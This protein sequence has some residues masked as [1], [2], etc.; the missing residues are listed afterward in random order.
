M[1]VCVLSRRHVGERE[2][3]RDLDRPM[4]VL[5]V[6][7]NASFFVTSQSFSTDPSKP[8]K[9]PPLGI[10]RTDNWEGDKNMNDN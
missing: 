4:P 7:S 8:N 5:S 2:R 10:R 3:E 6:S 1:C 9:K